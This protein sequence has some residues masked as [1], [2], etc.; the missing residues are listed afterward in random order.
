[1]PKTTMTAGHFKPAIEQGQ[2]FRGTR[3][4]A[5]WVERHPPLGR[6]VCT[7]APELAGV[8]TLDTRGSWY[9]PVS[10]P[11]LACTKEAVD[12]FNSTYIIQ[13]KFLKADDACL[14]QENNHHEAFRP[15]PPPFF[16]YEYEYSV[17]HYHALVEAAIKLWFIVSIVDQITPCHEVYFSRSLP[18]R[19]CT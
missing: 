6:V 1:M 9:V 11:S 14:R 4:P 3:F 7:S 18:C 5:R 19:C 2:S 15:H 8:W 13:C 10:P 12:N 16:Y 17:S